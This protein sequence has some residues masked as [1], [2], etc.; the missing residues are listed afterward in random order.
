M[1]C[2]VLYGGIALIV[3]ALTLPGC[4]RS[5][6]GGP[7][8]NPEA[9]AKIRHELESKS[10]AV[11][12]GA[13]TQ[14]AAKSTGWGTIK[15]R[16]VY[17]GTAPTPKAIPIT[18]DPEVCGK[19]PLNNESLLVGSDGGIAN[20]VV[21]ARDRKIE[22]HPDYEA[23]AKNKVVLDNHEC[24]F[25]PHVLALRAGQTL[26]VKNSDQ[27]SH[28]TNASFV[29]NTKRN[30]TVPVGDQPLE[31]PITQGEQAPVEVSCTIHPWMKGYLVVQPHPYVAVTGKDGSFELKNVPA[32]VP[33]E[34]Q[35]WHE[36]STGSGG[37]AV[38]RPE[39]KWQ[40]NGR[41]TVTLE[42]DQTLDLKELKV[43]ASALAAQ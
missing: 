20:V 10:G 35:V 41:F 36:A 28:N 1:N 30:E 15:G 34:F 6:A 4:G 43:P 9:V 19:H 21:Y 23:T 33:V 3:G 26:D 17:E 12:G 27:V 7:V 37:V 18:K 39:L 24:H 38:N 5:F 31:W 2:R 29:I 22:V 32:G 40:N 14:P 25:V 13:E 16:F 11:A 42:P 8:A